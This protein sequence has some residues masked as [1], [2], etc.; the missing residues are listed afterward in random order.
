MGNSSGRSA[1]EVNKLHELANVSGPEVDAPE[2]D[3]VAMGKKRMRS[4]DMRAAEVDV[5]DMTAL[6]KRFPIEFAVAEEKVVR[7]KNAD[8]ILAPYIGDRIRDDDPHFLKWLDE[9]N[10]RKE[11]RKFHPYDELLWSQR[12]LLSNLS[13]LTL[14]IGVLHGVWRT[15]FLYQKMDKQYA[16]LHGVSLSSIAVF[17]ISRSILCGTAVGV[18]IFCAIVFGDTFSSFLTASVY[19]DVRASSR[20]WYSIPISGAFAG[21]SIGASVTILERS[22]LTT[23]G[24]VIFFLLPTLA[25]AGIGGTYG[26]RVYRPYAENR[27]DEDVSEIPWYNRGFDW[28]DLMDGTRSNWFK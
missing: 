13:K 16:K 20:Q 24:K 26:Y 15:A 11:I 6:Y 7:K 27:K 23:K 3:V 4:S 22:S 17:E 12:Q 25:G 1:V 9:F 14:S 28:P 10:R 19:G 21:A 18:G 2:V 8:S 5:E